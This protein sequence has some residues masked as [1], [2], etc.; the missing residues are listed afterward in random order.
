[1]LR[2]FKLRALFA[3][4]LLLVLSLSAQNS[5]LTFTGTVK[6]ANTKEPVAYA[7]IVVK[8]K[9]TKNVIKGSVSG[10]DGKFIIASD[11]E[12]VFLEIS[13]IGYKTAL[14]EEFES[15]KGMVKLN[16]I[17][18]EEEA[19]DME[20]IEIT[21]EKSLIEFKLD[22]KVYNVGQDPNNVGL[23]AMDVLNNVPSVNV[24]IEGN[25]T[26]RGNSGVQILINGKPSVM[27]DDPSNAL[28][29]LTA[30]MIE[31]IEVITNPSGKYEAEGSAGIIN[32]VLKKEEKKGF[33]GSMSANTGYPANHSI[34]VSLNRRTEKFNFFTQFG[35]GY[36]S[37]PDYSNSE[38]KQFSSNTSVISDGIGYRNEN[39]YNITIGT[40]YYFN[41]YNTITL[42]GNFAFEKENQPSKTEISFLD[43]TN[44]LSSKYEREETTTADNP[45]WQYDLQYKKEFKN[46][47]DHILLFS[48]LGRFFGKKQSSE[49]VNTPIF[50]SAVDP[51]QK[52]ETDFH[53][54][55]YTF[56]LD[57]TNPINKK[58]TIEAGG[59]YERKDVGNDYAVFNLIDNVYVADSG[60]TNNFEY[61]QNV[62]GVYSTGSFESKKWGLK[63]GLRVE[64][65][66]LSTFLTNT[67][68]VNKQNYT[69]LFPSVHTSYKISKLVSV[70]AGYS[71]RIYRPRLWDLNPFFNIRNNYNIRRG[72]P[73]LLPEFT[74]SYELAG[75]L[76]LKKLTLNPSLYYLET[77]DVIERVATF[78]DAVSVTLPMNIG[79]R[80]KY[81]LEITAKYSPKKWLTFLADFNYGY[82]NREGNFLDQSFNFSSEQWTSQLTTKLKLPKGFDFEFTGNY[83]SSYETVQGTT[84]GFAF[85]NLGLR[86]KIKDGKFVVN[87]SVRDVFASRIRESIVNQADYYFYNFSKRGRFMTLGISYSFGKGEAMTYSGGKRHF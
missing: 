57:Y 26:L 7:T 63:L 38:N 33:N 17:I 47:K 20:E 86:K 8:S 42:S 31:S 82:F 6:D 71:K 46:N 84:S 62:L 55:N 72:N 14:V 85:L 30:D 54:A 41:K 35:V 76:L 29:T 10:D 44:T 23:G 11:S 87:A 69:N 3:T 49:F 15:K 67:N 68:Q 70:Q 34:G 53:E 2:S 32:I 18:L 43:S 64:N 27:S 5:A 79:T 21:D 56:K 4:F 65:T 16:D 12:N 80:Q 19:Q 60:L 1:M 66:E 51:N 61:K 40:D 24:D 28:G 48:T 25:V 22:K 73:E 45:K 9:A 75:V 52:T 13:F 59:Q 81:G 58:F 36:R 78:E 74:D 50:E 39:F 37:L 77:S 83:R